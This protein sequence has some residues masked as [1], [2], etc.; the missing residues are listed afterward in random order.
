MRN[1]GQVKDGESRPAAIKRLKVTCHGLDIFVREAAPD[2]PGSRLGHMGM[3]SQSTPANSPL[4]D[5]GGKSD[6]S[7]GICEG[8]APAAAQAWQ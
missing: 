8:E 1:V 7:A 4:S 6:H 2:P 3:H 5:E